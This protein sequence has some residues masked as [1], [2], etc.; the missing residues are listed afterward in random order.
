MLKFFS[1]RLLLVLMAFSSTACAAE[2]SVLPT[3]GNAQVNDIDKMGQ[4]V[5]KFN[6][7]LDT[8]VISSSYIFNDMMPILYV[9]HDYDEEGG[10]DWQF[11]SGNGD[12]D[13]SKMM[14]VS[15]KNIL[16]F[17]ASIT[18]V[19]DLPIGYYASRKFL[20]DPWVYVKQ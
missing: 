4:V 10:S 20:G 8:A 13:M 3:P 16:D 19:S 5:K 1:S 9:T 15:L 7:P 12:Y 17:D 11:H 6:I 18:A 14:L 2:N